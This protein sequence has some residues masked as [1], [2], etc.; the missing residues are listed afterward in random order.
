MADLTSTADVKAYLG[1]SGSGDDTLIGEIVSAVSA[2]IHGLVGHDYEAGPVS[3]EHHSAPISGAIVLDKPAASITTVVENTTTLDVGA[4]EL[5][6][7]RLLYR[8]A[9]GE[10]VAW[11][12]GSRRNIE[13][14]YATVTTIPDDLAMAAREVCAFMFKQTGAAQG[15]GR[16]GL[17]AQ[18]NQDAGTA[19]YF[20][21]A[22]R[23][24]PLSSVVLARYR[25]AI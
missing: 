13:V 25:R 12:T 5:E 6:G 14:T 17:S 1:V 3:S 15:G 8:K 9:N 23:Q 19:D 16:L 21:Q 24:L 20:A 10:T 22:L 7:D 4:Y 2:H 11:S 18:A